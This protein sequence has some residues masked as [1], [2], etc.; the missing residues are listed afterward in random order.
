MKYAFYP[1]CIVS[2]EQYGYE[3]SARRVLS[4]LGVELEELEGA[5]CCGAPLRHVNL[6]L[7]QYL[8]ARNIALADEMGLDILVLC[9]NCHLALR[10]AKQKMD[11]D[12]KNRISVEHKSERPK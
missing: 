10:D 12:I 2:T 8:S 5:S 11:G 4:E 3:I 1:G 7:T 9:P 6:N